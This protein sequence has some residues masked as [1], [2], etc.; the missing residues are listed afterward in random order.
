MLAIS[1]LGYSERQLP[2][3][4]TSLRN[5]FVLNSAQIVAGTLNV[6]ETLGLVHENLPQLCEHLARMNA[7]PHTDR[8]ASVSLDLDNLWSYLKTHGDDGWRDRPSY[9][10]RF[11][12]HMLEVLERLDLGSRSSSSASTQPS[13]V[14]T[15][16]CG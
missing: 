14:I 8:C 10:D 1:T 16:R 15:Q 2:P 12:P 3:L 6:N 5:V 9:L 7:H 4:R 13:R 11:V